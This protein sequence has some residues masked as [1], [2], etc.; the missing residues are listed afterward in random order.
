MNGRQERNCCLVMKR[1][2]GGAVKMR[3]MWGTNCKCWC[4]MVGHVALQAVVLICGSTLC[5]VRDRD[6]CGCSR[7]HGVLNNHFFFAHVGHFQS[8]SGTFCSGGERQ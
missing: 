1:T 8:S 6:A 7:S 3:T 4:L 2:F 5:L